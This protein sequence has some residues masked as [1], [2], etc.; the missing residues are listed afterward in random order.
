V[1]VSRILSL[2]PSETVDDPGGFDSIFL[3]DTYRA[4]A[5]L[6]GAPTGWNEEVIDAST[7]PVS[8]LQTTGT[9]YVIT[10]QPRKDLD[11]VTTASGLWIYR[12][13]GPEPRAAGPPGGKIT[14]ARPGSDEILIR[15]ESPQAGRVSVLE[16]ADPGWSAD[17]D[18]SAAPIFKMDPLGMAV[19]VAGGSHEIR[20]R[21]RT[22]GRPT[23]IL[24]S[25]LS[26][27]ALAV[28]VRSVR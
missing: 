14:Y 28:L 21:Y 26:A 17:V 24:L 18:G 27:F 5:A 11:L 15:S 22:P 25:L 10:W 2:R 16:A 20:L 1:A 4:V 3:A 12:I 9:K 23:G 8:A 13:D 19:H 7:W 6:T